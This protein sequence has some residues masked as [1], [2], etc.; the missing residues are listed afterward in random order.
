MRFGE[1][2]IGFAQSGLE[3]FLRTLLCVKTYIVVIGLLAYARL[4]FHDREIALSFRH[5]LERDRLHK[6]PGLVPVLHA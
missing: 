1:S 2:N 6:V 5:P 4:T 3:I